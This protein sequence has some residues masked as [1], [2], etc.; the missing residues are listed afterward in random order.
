MANIIRLKRGNLANLPTTGPA[1]EPYIA[2]DT[3]QLFYADGANVSPFKVASSDILGANAPNGVPLLDANGKLRSDQMPPLAIMSTYTV[4]TIAE[5]DAL[6]VQS[7]DVAIVTSNNTTYIYDGT[8]WIELLTPGSVVS[9]NGQTGVVVLSLDDLSDVN[10]AGAANG[11]VLRFDGT[12]WVAGAAAGTFVALTDTP[13]DYTG[14]GLK[15]VRV[16]SAATELEF[17]DE[18]DGGTF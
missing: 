3:G 13:A 16:N 15:L 2:L 10:T 8:A 4:A 18:I 14:H 12:N 5:R 1:G 6:T 9:V 17:T 11:S 7:G